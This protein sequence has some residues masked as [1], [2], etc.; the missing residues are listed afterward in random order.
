MTY[1]RLSDPGVRS[2]ESVYEV[3]TKDQIKP[4]AR[5]ERQLGVTVSLSGLQIA[6]IQLFSLRL[7]VLHKPLGVV[8]RTHL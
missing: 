5:V 7:H 4:P 8:V 6:N 3:T 2:V 1:F